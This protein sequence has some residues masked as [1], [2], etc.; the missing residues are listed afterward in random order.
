MCYFWPLLVYNTSSE[1]DSKLSVTL[2]H[3]CTHRVYSRG[4]K[5]SGWHIYQFFTKSAVSVF[6]T[7][8]CIYGMLWR[9]IRWIAMKNKLTLWRKFQG[10]QESPASASRESLWVSPQEARGQTKQSGCGPEVNWCQGKLQRCCRFSTANI[11]ST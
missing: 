2:Q 1:S 7:T 3:C 11:A 4:Q 9:A 5:F 8:I 6:M 10:A